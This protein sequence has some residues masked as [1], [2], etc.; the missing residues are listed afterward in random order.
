MHVREDEQRRLGPQSP[1]PTQLEPWEH[2]VHTPPQSQS[3]SVPSMTPLLH[4]GAWLELGDGGGTVRGDPEGDADRE[5]VVGMDSEAELLGDSLG[6][7]LGDPVSD[8][9]SLTLTLPLAVALLDEGALTLPLA[10]VLGLC[11]ATTKEALGL[12]LGGVGRGDWLLCDGDGLPLAGA[13][14]LDVA[15]ALLLTVAD[16]EGMVGFVTVAEAVVLNVALADGVTLAL[17]P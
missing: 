9:L 1:S 2:P 5:A 16:A 11:A 12:G 17:V 7:S 3:D 6:D 13:L 4:A 14:P 8:G 15:L 10:V